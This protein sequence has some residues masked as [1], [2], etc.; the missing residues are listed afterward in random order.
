VLAA[1]GVAAIQQSKRI[2]FYNTVD[3]VNQLE[4]EKQQGKAGNM[5]RQLVQTDTVILDEP[6][7]LP[8]PASG[9]ALFHLISHLYEKSSTGSWV[10][11][12][13]LW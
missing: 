11:Q 4:Q 5:A 7:Y 12:P 6:G 9:G 13:S 8:F 10:C 3:L 2:R 1:L